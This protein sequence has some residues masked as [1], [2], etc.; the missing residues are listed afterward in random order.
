MDAG[1]GGEKVDS[2]GSVYPLALTS[3]IWPLGF[4]D[5]NSMCTI[6]YVPYLLYN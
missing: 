1:H 3:T 6:A 4:M 2:V 5:C